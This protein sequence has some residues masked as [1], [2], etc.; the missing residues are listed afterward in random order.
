[1]KLFVETIFYV[2][3]Q[4]GDLLPDHLVNN[5]GVKTVKSSDIICWVNAFNSHSEDTDILL[6]LAKTS[7]MKSPLAAN[8]SSL[9]Q[10]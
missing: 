3:K 8:Q 4:S 1:M 7:E 10:F 5:I 6:C 2:S 9:C